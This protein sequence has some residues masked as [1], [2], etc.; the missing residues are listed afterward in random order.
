MSSNLGIIEYL[1]AG[2]NKGVGFLIIG[3]FG[4]PIL[5]MSSSHVQDWFDWLV[6]FRFITSHF[7]HSALVGN[8]QLASSQDLCLET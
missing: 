4:T 5:R 3:Y 1:G 2:Q 6:C 7:P 8:V